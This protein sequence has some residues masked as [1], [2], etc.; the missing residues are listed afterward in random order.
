MYLLES[1]RRGDSNKYTKRIFSG[2]IKWEIN[3]KNTRSADFCADQIDVITMFAGVP[4]VV[5]VRVHY[6]MDKTG[7]E[8]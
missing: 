6:N 5:I 2:R 3:E 4:N 7:S 8:S 1:P